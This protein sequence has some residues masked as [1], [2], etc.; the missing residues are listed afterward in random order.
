M[1]KVD[2]ARSFQAKIKSCYAHT[3]DLFDRENPYR[4]NYHQIIFTPR[5]ET[6]RLSFS[7]GASTGGPEGEE[8]IWNFIQV[9]PYFDA[10][11]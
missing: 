6:A 1:A 9:Q 4:L 7:D 2:E 8:L 5:S 10:E 11:G 3:T